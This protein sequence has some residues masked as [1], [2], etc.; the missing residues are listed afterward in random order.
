MKGIFKSRIFM[1]FVFLVAF[2]LVFGAGSVAY[3]AALA[4][5][6][7]FTDVQDTAW[8]CPNVIRIYNLGITTTSGTYNPAG[9]VTRAQMAAFLDRTTK[10]TTDDNEPYI[11]DVYNM[12]NGSTFSGSGIRARSFDQNGLVGQS[13]GAGWADYGVYGTT[14]ST[15]SSEAGVYGY[16]N[17]AAA[18]LKGYNYNSD[19]A[20]T[21][22]FGVRA[23]S[24]YGYGV[25]SQG[26]SASGDY[27]GYFS[28]Y[29]GLRSEAA[30]GYGINASSSGST[31][32][33]FVSTGWD[34]VYASST[35]GGITWGVN[36]TSTGSYGV[37]AN[38]DVSNGYAIYTNDRIYAGGGFATSASMVIVQNISNETL[39]P[40]DLVSVVGIAESPT[41][42]HDSPV[43]TVQKADPTSSTGVLGVI[44]GRY[45]IEQVTRENT[46]PETQYVEIPDPE[47]KREEPDLVP[48]EELK[49]V[50]EVVENAYSTTDPAA[51]GEYMTVIY[52]G[53]AQVNVD[54]TS[55]P[56]SVGDKLTLGTNGVMSVAGLQ[57]ESVSS[58]PLATLLGTALEDQNDSGLI[59]VLVDLR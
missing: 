23:Y 15:D 17:N 56:I 26:G 14:N 28:G 35:S 9:Y 8:F 30:T 3:G 50:E 21:S 13:N 36:A 10:A 54:G 46:Y 34:G 58:N 19:T 12:D 43:L 52:R 20:T 33:R 1:V 47:G 38:T 49:T 42:G 41:K 27:G 44:E 37:Y 39:Q 5:C 31:A 51:P 40:G 25:Y 6:G 22:S 53:L 55:Y 2:I 32:G 57:T 4:D 16:S 45:V 48:V 11:Y 24:S 29:N 18:G 59:W 7:P